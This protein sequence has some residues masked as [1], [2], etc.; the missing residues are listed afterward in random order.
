MVLT[1]IR[2]RYFI[3]KLMCPS[4]GI[5]GGH[6]MFYFFI[7]HFMFYFLNFLFYV[8]KALTD[9]RYRCLLLMCRLRS[10]ICSC[11]FHCT[12][13]FLM[14]RAPYGTPLDAICLLKLTYT[15]RFL[16]FDLIYLFYSK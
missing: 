9:I 4:K 6:F 11:I 16:I 7:V 15:L 14:D 10:I 2:C 13:T 5:L 8:E 1:D 12:S 3:F